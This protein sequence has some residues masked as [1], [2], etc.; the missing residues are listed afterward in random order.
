M[1]DTGVKEHSHPTSG[2]YLRGAAGRGILEVVVFY[3]PAFHP[4][5][6]PVLVVL[7]AAKFTLVV[8]FYMHLKAD[9]RVFTFLFGAPLLLAAVVLVALLF[10]LLG[11]LTLRGAAGAGGA[12]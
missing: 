4:V 10:L 3:V 11:A 8:M 12:G 6:V 9:S 5:L 2:V 7:S 1:A